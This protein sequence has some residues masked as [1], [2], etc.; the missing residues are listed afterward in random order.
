MSLLSKPPK[1]EDPLTIAFPDLDKTSA[2][3]LKTNSL[4]GKS[5]KKAESRAW[6]TDQKAQ[7]LGGRMRRAS[8]PLLMFTAKK[9]SLYQVLAPNA[10]SPVEEFVPI[11]QKTVS[12]TIHEVT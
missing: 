11:L 2:E 5:P 4:K 6:V 12:S 1:H 8:N 9:L 3:W 10:F 7:I